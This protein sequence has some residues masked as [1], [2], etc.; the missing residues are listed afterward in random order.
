MQQITSDDLWSGKDAVVKTL[1][2][3][4]HMAARRM[5]FIDLFEALY[6]IGSTGL[7]DG[8]LE[9]LRF[10]TDVILPLVEAVQKND[11]LSVMRIVREYSSLL[12]RKTLKDN[13]EQMKQLR[14]AGEKVNS[15]VALW[16]D[17][18]GPTLR[19]IVQ[20]V[21]QSKLFQLP[22]PINVIA[23]R[24]AQERLEGQSALSEES[25]QEEDA[26]DYKYIDSWERALNGLFLQ[27]GPYREYVLDH[28]R[29]GTQQGVKGLEFPRVMVILDDDEARGFLFSY[30]K[31]FGIKKPTD[32]D[33]KNMRE[34]NDSTI[35]RT[36]RLFY[37]SCSRASKSLAVVIYTSS[38]EAIKSHVV[39]QG[40]FAEEEVLII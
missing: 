21:A 5:G 40:W 8:S 9:G 25:G 19:D 10:F 39:S 34:G 29:F 6:P 18:S 35:D 20:E 1:L 22:D 32:N 13:T 12:S 4:H 2:L 36:L 3:E 33:L 37:V 24:W 7:L 16:R 23:K 11:H 31:I 17:G 14:A 28:S 27:I 26:A 30:D 15:L 38:P